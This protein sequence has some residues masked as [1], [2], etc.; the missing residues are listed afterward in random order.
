MNMK[1][2]LSFVLAFAAAAPVFACDR[3][4]C[5]VSNYYLGIM[6]QFTRSFVGVRYRHSSFESTG[7]TSLTDETF[8]TT[9]LWGRFYPHRKWQVLAFVP[10]QFNEQRNGVDAPIKRQGLGDASVLVNYN[11]LN[12]NNQRENMEVKH[13]LWFGGGVK[14]PTGQ[15]DGNTAEESAHFSPNFQLGTGSW[16]VLTNVLYTM[17]MDKLGFSSDFNYRINTTNKEAYRFGN[18]MSG[19]INGFYV[20]KISPK[21]ALM[22]W[23]GLYGEQSAQDTNRGYTVQESGGYLVAGQAG[24]DLYIGNN[25]AL[26]LNG[27]LPISQH[28]QSGYTTSGGRWMV[29]ATVMF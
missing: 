19:S 17:R 6:P 15:Y 18:R 23:A 9:E 8:R 27:M 2:I 13:Q 14:A 12:V 24:A 20:Q 4:G 1:K 16:D 11:L 25:W 29:G 7:H 22:P 5:G 3:C 21:L 10:Y 28:L 26:H